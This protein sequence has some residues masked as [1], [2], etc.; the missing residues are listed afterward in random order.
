MQ[1]CDFYCQCKAKTCAVF[2]PRA[3]FVHHIKSLSDL[4]QI[5]FRD[6]PSV[7]T[8]RNKL[9]QL[10]GKRLQTH[11]FIHND[12]GQLMYFLRRQSLLIQRIGISYDW[13][14]R[15]FQLM[16]KVCCKLLLSSDRI[17]QLFHLAFYRLCHIIKCF[18]QIPYF[19]PATDLCSYIILSFSK[20]PGCALQSVQWLC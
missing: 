11:A 19:V 5:F 10:K 8:K 17:L 9:H 3:W 2:L 16:G 13:R 14:H 7:I 6:S 12:S 4:L 20:P 1:L 18:W 15:C